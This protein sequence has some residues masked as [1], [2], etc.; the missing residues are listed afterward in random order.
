MT[1]YPTKILLATDGT[2]DSE[3]AARVTAS[4]AEKTGAELHVVHVG[5][6]ATPA[7]GTTVEG[8]A[9]PGQPAG[10]AERQ[11]KKL[12][13]RQVAKLREAGAN[14]AGSHL[15]IGQPAYEVVGEDDGLGVDLLVA[16]SG[17][18]RAVRRAVSGTMRRAALGR[19]SDYVVRTTR[20]PVLIVHPDGVLGAVAP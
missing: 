17:R 19:V 10:Y 18:P 6:P 3:T 12:L 1:E 7:S 8:A 16:G 9:L 20:C 2:E 13:E 4:L 14:V 15:R 5:Q 11:A